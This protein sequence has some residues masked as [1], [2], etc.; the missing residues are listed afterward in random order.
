MTALL[1]RR[2]DLPRMLGHLKRQ[3][4]RQGCSRGG[5]RLRLQPPQSLLQ[6]MLGK[7]VATR[8]ATALPSRKTCCMRETSC[9]TA[10]RAH[11]A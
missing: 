9:W 7:P 11:G 4:Q 6:L 2:Q 10:S 1:P 3:R 5:R 8:A